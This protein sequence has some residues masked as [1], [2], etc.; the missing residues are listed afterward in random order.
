[1][2]QTKTSLFI[3]T[4]IISYTVKVIISCSQTASEQ[5]L[6]FVWNMAVAASATVLLADF[7]W[8]TPVLM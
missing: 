7:P 4:L 2:P 1:M 8:T 3:M 6:S 5:P